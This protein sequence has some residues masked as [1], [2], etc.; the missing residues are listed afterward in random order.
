MSSQDTRNMGPIKEIKGDLMMS[1]GNLCHCISA[2]CKLGKGIAKK[3]REKFGHMN[4][5]RN[6]ETEVGGV[7]IIK[8]ENRY[9]YN[10]VTKDRYFQKPRYINLESSLIKMRKHAIENGIKKI[11]MPK[12]G[13]GLDKLNWYRVRDIIMK[14]F[15]NY[16]IEIT[17]YCL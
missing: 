13:C 7:S 3:F 15:Y 4:K 8:I 10:L 17:V 1:K 14:V 5:L 6:M 16:G 2:D 12:I 9:I 11:D